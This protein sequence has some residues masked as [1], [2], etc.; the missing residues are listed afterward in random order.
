MKHSHD[1]T[2]PPPLEL[3]DAELLAPGLLHELRQPL[4]GADAAATL[5]ERAA[6]AEL[7]RHEEW[8]LLRKQLARLA[9][10]MNGYEAL[11][12]ADESE[13]APF[14]VAPVVTRAV[15]L[16]AH[17]VRP[18]A[19]R[20]A[21]SSGEGPL[22]GFGAPGALVHAATNL[23]S[24]AIDAVEAVDRDARVAVRVLP[25]AGRRVEVRI[26]DEGV[27]IPAE[28]RGRIFEPRFTTKSPGKGTGLGLH[29]ARRLMGR[30]GGE[31]YLVD[32]TDPARLSWAVTEF[33]IAV[34][35]P[36]EGARP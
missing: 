28:V 19:R 11:L 10:V 3:L 24:N 34:P 26:S 15:D 36:P 35:A 17:R 14:A 20:F 31:I 8:Q 32:E 6:G 25:A 4:M 22:D 30:F 21:F 7:G 33:C 27:G 23:L 1:E 18:L 16:L 13:P 9:E 5:L 2:S 29:I 12:R